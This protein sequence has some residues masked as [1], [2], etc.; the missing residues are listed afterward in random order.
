MTT[1]E[2][3]SRLAKVRPSGKGYTA[4]CP[5][6]EDK[7]PSLAVS[8]GEDGKILLKCF[9][10]CLTE[11]V[12]KAIGLEMRDL[13][14]TPSDKPFRYIAEQ[15]DTPTVRFNGNGSHTTPKAT[16]V[17]GK[18]YSYTDAE[19]AVL[20]ENVRYQPKD[21][22]QRRPDGDGGY[23]YNLEGIERVPYRL[24]EL[25]GAMQRADAEI[26]LTEG[27]KDADNLRLLGFTASSFKNWTQDLSRYIKDAH[28]VLFRDHDKSGVKQANDA[29]RI[30]AEG[31]KTVKVVDLFDDDHLPDKRG[32][33]VSDWLDARRR[34]GQSD[35]EIGERL[36]I[37][38]E[39][40]PDWSPAEPRG[41]DRGLEIEFLNTVT[42]LEV[43]WLA[44][45]LIP[46]GFF[47]LM[48]GIEGIGKTYAMLDIAKRLTRG[49]AMPFS[50]EK[51][52]PA[53]VLFL[54]IEDSPEYILKPRFEK[55][56]GDC[57]RLAVL[58]GHFDFS[59]AGFARLEE[60]IEAH[61][62]KFVLIDPLFS[63]TGRAD[64]NSTSDVRPI[65]DRLNRIAA[66]YGIAIVGI[67]H[68]NKSKGFGDPRNAGAHSVAW[69]Q[70]CRSGLIVGH[71]ADD[72]SKRGIAQHKLNVAAESDTVYGFEIDA[73]G[74]FNWTGES[75][76]S[77]RA[78]LAHKANESN[79]ER[80]VIDD[81]IRFLKEQLANGGKS[82]G[83]LDI[84]ARG[85]GIS[86][87]SLNRAKA[88]LSIKPRKT[89]MAGGWIWELPQDAQ[90]K[91]EDAQ[92]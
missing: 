46:F 77:I 73:D 15:F 58:R 48:D 91:A 56:Q 81:A 11:S 29:A 30:I 74:V 53:N 38:A 42:A 71:H 55:M 59:D 86:P 37:I 88:R 69:L 79:E 51:H 84:E 17:I 76:L 62:I 9:T 80:S 85:E 57:S 34:E 41:D 13:F 8:E 44:M 40:W 60:T 92:C 4:L 83:D 33:D 6:H 72:K 14:V 61:A 18:V 3:L 35:D 64:I 82:R 65:T 28:A 31:A 66:S 21:F 68:I 12:L 78:M 70:G 87:A 45:P 24:P 52:D 26:W 2:I 39:S 89:G 16:K 22:R 5:A 27:E 7:N 32:R 47:T 43:S 19:G 54:S 49:E 23:I 75:D 1:S 63:F 36:A 25:I 90:T 67:R 20:Y 50:G 10:G